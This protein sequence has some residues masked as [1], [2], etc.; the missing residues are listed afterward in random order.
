V[1][2]NRQYLA[3]IHLTAVSENVQRA[4]AKVTKHMALFGPFKSLT[5][6]P[7]KVVNLRDFALE[8]RLD[9]SLIVWQHR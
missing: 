3:F 6:D 2:Q 5:N 4:L 1:N 8:Q 7:V 9:C